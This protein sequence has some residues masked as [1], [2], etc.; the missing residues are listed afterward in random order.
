[1]AFDPRGN[2]LF[3]QST[4]DGFGIKKESHGRIWEVPVVEGVYK[5]RMEYRDYCIYY[6]ER[7][8]DCLIL[9]MVFM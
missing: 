7:L 5:L 2:A 3:G 4:C 9:S 8:I 6:I 1:M